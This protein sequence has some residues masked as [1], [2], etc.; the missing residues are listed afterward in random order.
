MLARWTG[1][2]PDDIRRATFDDWAINACPHH[3]PALDVG[4]D[5][6]YH[7]AWFSAGRREQGLLYARSADGGRTF[8]EPLQFGSLQRSSHPQVA[9]GPQR[10]V[11]AWKESMGDGVL[12]VLTRESEDGGR[13]WPAPAKEAL[14]TSGSS[15]HPLLVRRGPELFLSWFTA[16]DGYRL[17]S[18]GRL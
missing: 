18:L 7:L 8:S 15:D 3:G 10:V 9:S 13:T 11:L 5:G 12:V 2:V 17:R 16:K 1:A 6:G 14:R 4:P